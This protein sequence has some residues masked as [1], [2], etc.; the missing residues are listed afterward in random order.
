M[1]FV[2]IQF[3]FF[4]NMAAVQVAPVQDVAMEDVGS[5]VV[6]ESQIMR[7]QLKQLFRMFHEDGQKTLND[8]VKETL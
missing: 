4:V 1:L 8:F 6:D 5:E 7:D 2:S 3:Q